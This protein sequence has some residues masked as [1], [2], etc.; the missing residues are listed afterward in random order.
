[1]RNGTKLPNDWWIQRWKAMIYILLPQICGYNFMPCWPIII[2]TSPQAYIPTKGTDQL[3]EVSNCRCKLPCFLIFSP[4]AKS[5]ITLRASVLDI[6][7]Q[8]T[9]LLP[10]CCE[11]VEAEAVPERQI[12]GRRPTSDSFTKTVLSQIPSTSYSSLLPTSNFEFSHVL[13]HS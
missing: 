13:V 10:S 8:V 4:L 9:S 6:G 3:P 2:M 12:S 5:L 1:M 11:R 7:V